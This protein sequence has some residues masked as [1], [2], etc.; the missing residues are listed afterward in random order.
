MKRQGWGF[1]GLRVGG[2][3]E[4]ASTI[5]DNVSICHGGNPN[6]VYLV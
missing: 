3:G 6:Q 2:G 1:D 5:M 4:G